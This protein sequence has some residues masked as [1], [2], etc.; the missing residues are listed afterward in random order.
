MRIILIFMQ[1]STQSKK[2]ILALFSSNPSS[3]FTLSDII[4]ALGDIPKSSVYRIVDALE[5]CGQIRKVATTLRGAASYQ[6]YDSER[7]PH[8]M[9]I[10]C[11][12]CGKTVHIDRETSEKI[13]RLIEADLGFSDV[14]STVLRGKCPDCMKKEN[15]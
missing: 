13:E 14:L 5:E 7:C 12:E 1:Y 8:H 4:S 3:S 10:R 6:Y 2:R 15:N 9:H 11:T